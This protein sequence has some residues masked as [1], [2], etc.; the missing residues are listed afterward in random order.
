MMMRHTMRWMSVVGGLS[1]AWALPAMAEGTPVDCGSVDCEGIRERLHPLE[2]GEHKDPS[3]LHLADP[4]MFRERFEVALKDAKPWIDLARA[5][6]GAAS[7]E[8]W[9][10]CQELAQE[11]N[12]LGH[13]A[14]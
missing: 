11:T 2:L 8:A 12:I 10:K 3:A 1:F 9:K 7:R 4:D 6:A 14:A 5:E 13:F